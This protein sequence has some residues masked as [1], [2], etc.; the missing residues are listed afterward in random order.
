M[1]PFF[2]ESERHQLLRMHD[3]YQRWHR[4]VVRMHKRFPRFKW[5]QPMPRPMKDAYHRQNAW[6]WRLIHFAEN[7]GLSVIDVRRENCV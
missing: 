1:K 7:R 2:T 3:Q 4:V 5:G 6:S